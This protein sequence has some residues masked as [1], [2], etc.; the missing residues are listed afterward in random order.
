MENQEAKSTPKNEVATKQ[1]LTPKKIS[2]DS[3]SYEQLVASNTAQTL[4]KQLRLTDKQIAKANQSLLALMTDEKLSKCSHTSIMRFAYTTALCDY[5]HP[6][7]IAGVPYGNS[8]QA[9]IQY[10]GLVEDMQATG[11]LKSSNVVPIYK[12][13]DYKAFVNEWGYKQLT[14][15]D[16]IEL[17]DIFENMEVLGYYAVAECDNGKV[18]S[19]LM[20]IE[21]IKQHADSYSVSYRS[22]KGVWVDSF[23]KMARKTV[24]KEVAR[25]FLLEYP[26]DRI[27]FAL[28][29][30]QAVFTEKG[31]EYQD[32]PQVVDVKSQPSGTINNVEEAVKVE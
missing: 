25:Q 19:C 15:P 29:L 10:Q 23:E 4:Q 17:K 11:H 9:Q 21:Q 30:D 16:K 13:V 5:K 8:V 27:A 1:D 32:N 6:N 22:G 14:L 20:S 26:F 24:Q 3:A 28:K 18:I 2:L 31:V 12:G 7:A